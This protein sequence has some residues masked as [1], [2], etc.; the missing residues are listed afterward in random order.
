MLKKVYLTLLFA[1]IS[2]T[3]VYSQA[4]NAS[5]TGII[6][7]KK[8][9]E[10]LPF[11]N[12]V[13]KNGATQVAGGATDF[14]GKYNL[15]PI[16]PGTYDVEIS[17]V[18][19]KK[20]RQTGVV[21]KGNII[22]FLDIKL[23]PTSVDI[24]E[25]EIVAY[26]VPLI[27]KDGGANQTTVTRE[28]IRNMSARNATAIIA[29]VGG[30]QTATNGDV[31]VRGARAE[32]TFTYIDGVKVRGSANLPKASLEE[33][34]VITGGIPANFGDAT[35]GIVRI[36]TRGASS[37]FFGGFDLLS[38]G[39]KGADGKGLGLDAYANNQVEGYISGP[40]LS[41]KDSAGN[42]VK[43]LLG[44][45]ISGNYRNILDNRPSAV[46]NYKI[47]KEVLEGLIKNP[48]SYSNVEIGQGE[49]PNS[50]NGRILLNGSP[51]NPLTFD[52][53]R[54]FDVLPNVNTL[55]DGD[56]EKLPAKQNSGQKAY[57]LT[58][59]L[60]VNTTPTVNL[61]FG[62]TFD[63]SNQF[64]YNFDNALLNSDNNQRRTD[65]TWRGFGSFTQRFLNDET[66]SN[67]TVKNAFYTIMVDYTQR[68]LR[69]QD[70]SHRDNFFDYGY[71]GKF[72]QIQLP[73]YTFL[74][75]FGGAYFHDGFNQ[76]DVQFTPSDVN[77]DL[78][79]I[80]NSLFELYKQNGIPIRNLNTVDASALLNGIAPPNVYEIWRNF[81]S[82][83]NAYQLFDQNQFRIT[84]SGSGDIKNHAV[85]VGF[86]FEQLTERGFNLSPVRLWSTARL[87]VNNH[88]NNLDK[89]EIAS[90][91]Y[92]DGNTYYTYNRVVELASQAS[93]D[94]NLRTS[95]GL[96]PSGS[97]FLYLDALS[98]DQ[99]DLS[100]F[101][102]DELF[103]GGQNPLVGYYGYD[104]KGKKTSSKPSFDDFFNEVDEN[105]NKTRAIGAFEPIYISGYLMDKFSFDDIIFN[106]GLRIDRFDA[107][108]SVLKD[109]YVL[110]E[111]YTAGSNPKNF[112][113]PSNIKDDYVVYTNS[114]EN[115]TTLKGF[116]NGSTWYNAE[117]IEVE[118]PSVLRGDEGIAPYLVN[119]SETR[120]NLNS[121]SF[122]DYTPQVIFMPRIAF[123]FPIS[124]QAVFSAHYDVLTQR[125][126]NNN[127]L[128]PINYLFITSLSGNATDFVSNPAL[129]PTRTTDYELGF[130]QMISKSS[131]LKIAGFY[132]ELKDMIQALTLIEAW[133]TTYTTF[134]N[135]DFGTIKGLTLSYDMRRTN[136]ITL[137]ASYTLQ[138][139]NATGSSSTTGINL[140]RSGEPNLRIV[141][142]TD[143][144]QRH[145]FLATIDY[146]YGS[147]SDYNG[148]VWGGK[149]VFSNA[150][151][152][153]IGN[154]GSGSPYSGQRLANQAAFITGAA[155][156]RL[157]GSINGSRLP[158]QF[159]LNLQMDKS[160]ELKVGKDKINE[161]KIAN[162]NAYLL[163]NNLLNTLNI[164]DVYRYTGSATD[165]GFLSDPA[166][167]SIINATLNPS[168][169][170]EL[171]QLKQNNPFNY[172]NPRT[173][174]LGLRLDF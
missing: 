147:G 19:Y 20:M 114:T 131:S 96:D 146:R 74:D 10:T 85:T 4:G 174:Q 70:D 94:R 45:F 77:A 171:Y 111:T 52:N 35:G 23:D 75:S 59:K 8:S 71:V 105:G 58:T 27:T 120:T 31:S 78:S 132:R 60:N 127:R 6:K 18:G 95:L 82:Q 125:P 37:T 79:A 134:G 137:R 44:F 32:N 143:Q 21:I 109:Q 65:Y 40:L 83:S 11:I 166:S 5:L 154:L 119:E 1:V 133:P 141:N 100:F 49:D 128:D 68:K 29:T 113:I 62:G 117:G 81:G 46:G 86:E 102:P 151:V 148:P 91:Q 99:L 33:V 69:D 22:N 129:K 158:S 16:V 161:T 34:S 121:K 126:E 138:F 15:K 157:D 165:D 53:I 153:L 118:D 26:K 87:L 124:D 172:G 50:S 72:D 89:T 150:G 28:E 164:V 17:S 61:S 98:P 140:A 51:V 139:A 7:D 3:L 145:Q 36:T 169:F 106:I 173:I 122:K 162:L 56:W 170:R 24:D 116:R 55:K 54:T 42:K 110:G 66:D 9:G 160:F 142:P 107:N 104:Y 115:P 136:N 93:F 2:L 108:Q 13:I 39:F 67:A 25:V 103:N 152:N 14:D 73:F 159:T 48:V 84:S 80:T 123:S 88:I 63:Y 101:N 38:S 47:K 149:Q 130:Q 41:K 144:D 12:I 43:P 155:N 76:Y 57:S 168:S 30:V 90:E 112:V 167:Q 97:D 64:Q 135:I 163:V 92:I 156:P